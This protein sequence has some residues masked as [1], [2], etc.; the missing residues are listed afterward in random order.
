MLLDHR[1]DPKTLCEKV[2]DVQMACV[3]RLREWTFR[4]GSDDELADVC[5]QR[6]LDAI[7]AGFF[8]QLVKDKTLEEVLR[9]GWLKGT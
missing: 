5:F 2:E 8:D 7:N 9:R 6:K 3:L 1:D 4:G